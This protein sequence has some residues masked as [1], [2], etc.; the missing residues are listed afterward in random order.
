[1]ADTTQYQ[2]SQAFNQSFAANEFVTRNTGSLNLSK[3]LVNLRGISSGVGLAINLTYAAGAQGMLGLPANWG[4]GIA[5]VVPGLSLT[6]QGKTSIID[7]AW[8][9]VTGYQSG[10]RYVNDHGM[11]FQSITPPQPLPSGQPGTYSFLLAYNDGARD[12]FDAT[13][14]LVEHDDLFG[15]HVNY[16]Y[17]DQFSGPANN[18]LDH[19]VDSLGQTTRFQYGANQIVITTPDGT[20]TTIN[21]SAQGVQNVRDPLGNVTVFGYETV[22]GQNVVA[23]VQYPTGLKTQLQYTSMGY[24]SASGA[25]GFFPAVTDHYHLD[26]KGN[27]LEHTN[28]AFGTDSGGATFTGMSAGYRLSGSADSLME[29]NNTLYAYDV[30][31]SRLDAGG[32]VLAA[33]RV[34]F[35]YL[36]LPT[37]EEHY[38]VGN[39]GTVGNGYRALYTYNIDPDYHA[40]ATTYA[41]PV[42]TQQFVYDA[43]QSA[44]A[45]LRQATVSYDAFGHILASEEFL[46][47]PTQKTYVS[48]T[49]TVNTYTA[50]SWGGEMPLTEIYTDSLSGYQRQVSYT[51]T[52]DQK[53][54]AASAVLYRQ[55]AQAAWSPWKTKSYAYDANGR[56]TSTTLAW[57]PGV[58]R[59]ASGVS[60]STT[61][62]AY[63]F[64][65]ASHGYSLSTTD[66]VGNTTVRTYDT[67]LPTGPVIRVTSPLGGTASYAYDAIGRLTT[68]TDPLGHVTTTSYALAAAGGINSVTA[69]GPTGY[70]TANYYDALGRQVTVMDN[71]DPTRSGGSAPNR[72]LRQFT[73]DALG[74]T[75]GCVD[76][77]GLVS[78]FGYDSLSRQV[79]ATDPMGNV[80]TTAYDDAA[81]TVTDAMNGEIRS[82]TAMDGFGRT[83]SVTTRPDSDDPSLTYA[84]QQQT[85][86][87]GFGLPAKAQFA[88]MPLAGSAGTVLYQASF[89]RNVEGA[90]SAEEYVGVNGAIV[91]TSRSTSY[92]LFGNAIGYVKQTAYNDGRSYENRGAALAFDAAGRLV[93]VTNQLGQVEKYTYDA[94]GRMAT[95][96]RFDRTVLD[97]VYDAVGQLLQTSWAGGSIVHTYLPNGRV[98]ST[99]CGSEV[100]AYA[101]YLDGGAKSVTYPDGCTQTYTLD[102]HSRVVAAT[103]ASGASSTITFDSYGR[104]AQRQHAGDTLR[105]SYGTVNHATGVLVGD[106]LAG[107]ESIARTFAYDGFGQSSSVVSKD[108]AGQV[109]LAA[110]YGRDA[111]GRLTSLALSSATSAAAA[112]NL[113]RQMRYDGLNQLTGST[114]TYTGGQPQDVAAFAYD[115][116]FNVLQR[117]QGGTTQSYT[118][119]E[120][121]QLTLSGI[122]YDANGR[123]IADGTGRTYAYNVLD[124]LVSVSQGTSSLAAYGYYPDGALASR[125]ASGAA[126]GFYYNAGAANAVAATATTGGTAAGTGQAA[127]TSFLIDAASR[128]AAYGSSGTPAYYLPSGES[129]SLLQQDGAALA[130]DYAAY[131]EPVGDAAVDPSMSF[132]WRQEF[133][134]P[135]TGLV[136]LRARYY[137][138]ALMAFMSM[139]SL[140]KDNRYAYCSGDP[141]NLVDPN[142]HM[143]TAEII[144]LV[145]GAV[146]GIAATV[147]TGVGGGIV[148]AAVFGTESVAASVG[149]TALAG[150]VGA[151]A[152]DATNAAIAG[153][154]FTAQRALVDLVSGGVGGVVGAGVGGYV[155][156]T[157]M[158]AALAQGMSQ[159]A[160][161]NIGI[162]CSSVAGGVAGAAA[163]SGATSLMTGQPFFSASTA[164]SMAV[165]A[166]AGVGGG[167]L[168]SG[169]Y[170]GKLS[171]NLIPVALTEAELDLITPAKN[172]LT[173]L[174]ERLLVMAPQDEAVKSANQYMKLYKNYESAQTLD[175][176]PGSRTYDTIAAHGAGNTMFASVEYQPGGALAGEPNYVR[177]IKGSLFAKYLL[178]NPDLVGGT[179]TTNQTPVKLM[180]CFG[181]FSNAQTIADA[182]QRPV[183]GGYPEI[184]RCTFTNWKMFRPS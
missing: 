12:Y 180:T 119:N 4:F 160:I 86:Y 102:A 138:P 134:D 126:L 170:L 14:K 62:N 148:A 139:D 24:L 131:G 152:G 79:S 162:I 8:S 93:S 173:Q 128:R 70:L 22:A 158:S 10:L 87:D 132:T 99:T 111:A 43:G 168:T 98:A 166:A 38:L 78:S 9:D 155:G 42:L 59:A 39:D 29:S 141:I 169:A 80:A 23:T 154:T 35:N 112:V 68:E 118:Y 106:S 52:S 142:G 19:I 58:S 26:A 55:N 153:Q 145:A 159:R 2:G 15:N 129:T 108:G 11:K 32:K 144:G 64:D 37:R 156:R 33:S 107:S 5:F 183:F 28:Y 48:Q 63:A 125:A 97:Y 140:T 77:L 177:P 176:Q 25:Q 172:S 149:A 121:D 31:V 34:Y 105:Y 47:D 136:Y 116:N 65:A 16:F 147:L 92:D 95:R 178:Q 89:T 60:S 165:G 6:T 3:A 104:P 84:R 46:Y 7:P 181:A 83:T 61:T 44:Y 41:Q 50:A 179:G 157:A 137:N 27:I 40:R 146:V 150:G 182:L 13:G 81:G 90:I 94:N 122:N 103:D 57:S 72:T 161:T 66:A 17:T 1:M 18:R 133:A 36:H 100:L 120:I 124:Q 175:Y 135:S 54:I 115:G 184:D 82:V 75:I 171:A 110:T 20:A 45:P 123:M 143:E 21:W 53:N 85:T 56:V 174:R 67:S 167:L 127:W 74:R 113:A 164:I 49:S 69:T 96:T 51:L 130:L 71:G 76:D 73:Y 91:Q 30:L 163:A 151:L 101:Y 117:A 109:M 88:S 114:T